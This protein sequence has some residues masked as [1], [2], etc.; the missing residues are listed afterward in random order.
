[1]SFVVH[2]TPEL[3]TWLADGLEAGRDPGTLE[4]TMVAGNMAPAVAHAIVDA[5]IA[6]RRERRPAPDGSLTVDE[7]SLPYLEDGPIWR[8]E[9]R[10]HT[11]DRVVRVLARMERPVLAVLGGLLDAAECAELIELARPRL[12]PSTVVD[13]A[14]GQDVVASH[15]TSFGMFFRPAENALVA[16]LEARVSEVMNLPVENGEGFQVLRYPAGAETTAHVDFLRPTNASNAASIAR[17]GQRVSTLI[18]Y[19]NDVERGGETVFPEVGF[20]VSPERGNAVLF[21]YCNRLGQV[22]ER[23]VHGGNRVLSGEK[24]VLTKWMRQRRFVP[25]SAAPP[26][27]MRPG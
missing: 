9:P 2:F 7:A 17:S 4:R 20:V 6:A 11:S 3:R 8:A 22:D 14:S 23:T 16:R 5:F 10:I 12:A 25:A 19:L 15:R 26:D 18:S 24:W 1:M 27:G 13:P 21:E